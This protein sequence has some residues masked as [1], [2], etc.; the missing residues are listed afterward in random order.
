MPEPIDPA[1]FTLPDFSDESEWPTDRLTA[2][3]IA[4]TRE[5]D[6]RIVIAETPERVDTLVQ[7]YQ[8]AKGRKDGDPWEQPVGAVNA[9]PLGA[10]ATVDGV[11]WRSRIPN[12]VTKPGDASDPQNFR[13]WEKV[14]EQPQQGVWNPNGYAYKPGDVFTYEGKTYRV[15][16]AHS[17]Q[18]DWLPSALPALYQVVT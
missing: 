18:P 8:K 9:Y 14:D 15:R 11:R 5:L 10:I 3:R 4:V 1:D 12:N 2:A 16:Q 13:W 7:R 17:S 6:R